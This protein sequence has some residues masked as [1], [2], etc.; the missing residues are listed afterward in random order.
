MI[1]ELLFIIVVVLIILINMLYRSVV[2]T[3]K[4]IKNGTG[5]SGF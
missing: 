4:G 3:T 1:I 5:L 2:K